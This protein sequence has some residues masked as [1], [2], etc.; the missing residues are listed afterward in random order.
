MTDTCDRRFEEE[1]LS[2]YVDGMLTQADRQQVEV[3]LN[4]CDSCRELVHELTTVRA[5]ARGTSFRAPPDDQWR[6]TPRTA[7][8][9]T[10]RGLGW[11]LLVAWLVLSATYGLYELSMSDEPLWAKIFVFSGLT[12]VLMLL[13][14]ALL[15]RFVN[16]R[17]DP[18]R[19]VEK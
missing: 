6:D 16:L 4:D 2:G 14:S 15:D 13:F 1:Q 12:G 11:I 10:L 19:R 17:T 5:A 3:H 7:A 8:S 18:Y 9:A